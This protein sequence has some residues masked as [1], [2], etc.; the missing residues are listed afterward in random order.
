LIPPRSH[1]AALALAPLAA[2][3]GLAVARRNRRFDRGDGVERAPVPVVSVGNLAVGGTGKT[4]TTAWLAS[5]L[6]ARGRRP[7]I[8]TRGYGGRAGS[9]P[10]E[11][12]RGAG[13]IVD[14]L[15]GGDEPVLLAT[16]TSAIVI[17]GSDRVA[18]ARRAAKLG[19]DVILLDDGF[20]HRRLAR[21]LD[22]VL[23]DAAHPFGNGFLLPAGPLREPPAS[24]R[25]AGVVVLTRWNGETAP[26]GID[27]PVVRARH[28]AA[29]FRD[30]AGR[31]VAPPARAFAFAGIASPEG[32]FASLSACG[33]ELA[34]TRSFRDHHPYRDVELASIAD[35]AH[36]AGAAIVTTMKDLVRLS[37]RLPDAIALHVEIELADPAPLE[38]AVDAVLGSTR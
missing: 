28:R 11:V 7:A 31:E 32:F 19:A 22:L 33:V 20:Q 38:R 13:P 5:H 34:G 24:L 30:A 25:R 29:G 2:L 8:V 4:P 36:R 37:G 9:G 18:G 6:R 10:L 12:S 23:L 15:H 3:Y 26:A 35:G 21:D 16:L 1:A 14:A 17:A 27:A